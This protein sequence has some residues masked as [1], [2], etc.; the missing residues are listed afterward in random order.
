M[1]RGM[2]WVA[3]V[4]AAAWSGWRGVFV[5]GGRI[6]GPGLVRCVVVRGLSDEFVAGFVDGGAD[7][8]LGEGVGGAHCY[9]AGCDVD[10]DGGD[11]G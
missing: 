6:G 11:A 7:V 9:C 4:V 1:A 2:G 10:L 8:G 5:A 3:V